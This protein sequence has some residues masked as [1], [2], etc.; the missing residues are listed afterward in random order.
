MVGPR[1][2]DRDRVTG[3]PPALGAAALSWSITATTLAG[4]SAALAGRWARTITVALL[5]IAALLP[6]T[7]TRAVSRSLA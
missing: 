6:T 2:E 5:L 7:V 3:L 4:T 1:P